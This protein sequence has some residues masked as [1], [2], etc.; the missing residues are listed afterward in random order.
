MTKTI[1]A[2]RLEE[3]QRWRRDSADSSRQVVKEI[4]QIGRIAAAHGRFNGIRQFNTPPSTRF[5]GSTRILNPNG[6]SIG[7]TVFA[8]LTAKN[9]YTLE[10]APF[11]SK[12]A[13]PMGDLDPHIIHG[14][15][16]PPKSSTQTASQLVQLYLQAHYWPLYSAGNNRPHL[17][18]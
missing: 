2:I 13:L 4:W 1:Y 3:R 18:T 9:P 5:L 17:R 15:L 11:S 7:S 14:F 6:I 12:T 16:G 10:R 8:H